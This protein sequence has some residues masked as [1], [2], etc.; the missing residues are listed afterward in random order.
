MPPVQQKHS[1]IMQIQLLSAQCQMGQQMLQVHVTAVT[2]CTDGRM[3]TLLSL[4]LQNSGDM[5]TLV[6]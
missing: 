2:C 5:L 6:R 4:T 1:A 3:P